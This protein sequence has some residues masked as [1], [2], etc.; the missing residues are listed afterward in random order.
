[1]QRATGTVIL[2]LLMVSVVPQSM[3]G[4]SVRK[5]DNTCMNE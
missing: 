4:I 3:V 1:M 5:I 2:Y